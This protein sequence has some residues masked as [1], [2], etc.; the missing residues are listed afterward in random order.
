MKKNIINLS[1]L[2]IKENNQNFNLIENKKLN[3]KS[4]LFWMIII[5]FFGISYISY[6]LIFY[7]KQAGEPEIFL[8]GYFLFLEILL[9]FQAV[10]LSTNIFYFSRDIEN[11]LPL[12]F[13]PI[14]ILFAKFNTLIS[15][16]YGTEL[17]FAF[18]PFIIYGIYTDMGFLFYFN[19]ILILFIFPIF[20]GLVVSV[21]TMLLMKLIKFFKNKDL[22][23]LIISFILIIFI[24]IFL[25]YLMKNLF[26]D[27]NNLN[28]FNEKLIKINNYFLTINPS[29]NL[30]LGKNIF[31]NF[32]KIILINFFGIFIFYFFGNK[33]YLKQLLK[34]KFYIKNNKKINLNK[35][36]K[37]NKINISYIKK[38]FKLLFKN[39]LFFMQI[40]YSIILLTITISILLIILIPKIIDILNMEEYKETLQNL[41]FDFECVCLILGLT[42]IIGLFNYSSVTAFSREGQDA[43][44][45]KYLPIDF[46]KQFIWKNIPQVFVNIISSVFILGVIFCEIPAIGF[47]YIFIIFILNIL[48]NFINSFILCLIDLFNPKINWK[49]EYEIFKNNRNKLLQYILIILNIL[50]LIYFNKIFNDYNLDFSLIIFGIILLIIFAIFNLIIF[51]LKNKLLKKIN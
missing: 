9:I 10:I 34:N 32:L 49:A 25:N 46:Y 48:L 20:I 36:C 4:S 41:E 7:L 33:F 39:P 28:E 27:F 30:L 50:F 44:I 22:T 26:N 18:M 38:E 11:I 31:I 23:Q 40:I 35:K 15:M 51:K 13:K 42:Q 29:I 3:K 8:N 45:M 19:L 17:I 14:E 6:K 12:P 2:F 5:L 47:K 24:I 21:A 16:L 43:Y 37:K 1:K